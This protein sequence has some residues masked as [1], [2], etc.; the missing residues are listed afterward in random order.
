M[1]KKIT[2]L[3]CAKIFAL[4]NTQTLYTTKAEIKKIEQQ[5][6]ALNGEKKIKARKK[7]LL[8]KLA[9]DILRGSTAVELNLFWPKSS[10]W[11]EPLNFWS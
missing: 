2:V 9:G 5:N 8:L 3:Q 1:K 11:N 10:I 7:K 6:W 4:K